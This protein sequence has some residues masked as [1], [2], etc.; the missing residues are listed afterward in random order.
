MLY[1]ANNYVNYARYT[2]D[3][4]IVLVVFKLCTLCACSRHVL[5]VINRITVTDKRVSDAMGSP[6]FQNESTVIDDLKQ[7]KEDLKWMQ[8]AIKLGNLEAKDALMKYREQGSSLSC[9][10]NIPD[11][12]NMKHRLAWRQGDLLK[13]LVLLTQIND[14]W[15][16][17]VLHIFK[18][19]TTMS[20]IRRFFSQKTMKFSVDIYNLYT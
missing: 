10:V 6:T 8:S 11:Y 4:S 19:Y 14:T 12:Y 16:K 15:L 1:K 20:P 13:I 7:L 9:F 2:M 5:E 17:T 18:H 3:I